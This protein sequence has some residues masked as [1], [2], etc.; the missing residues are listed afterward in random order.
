MTVDLPPSDPQDEIAQLRER[1]DELTE[2]L[3]Q[4][5]DGAIATTAAEVAELR[6]QLEDAQRELQQL[7]TPPPAPTPRRRLDGF[8]EVEE[9]NHE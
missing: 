6:R 5:R 4:A 8:F 3:R 2:E 9:E 7:R 1:I